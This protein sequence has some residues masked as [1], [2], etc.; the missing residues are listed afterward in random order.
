MKK[1]LAVTSFLLISAMSLAACSKHDADANNAAVNYELLNDE[2][3]ADT[4]SV[5]DGILNSDGVPLDNA[6]VD[7]VATAPSNAL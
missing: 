5:G 2:G 7:N 6:S 4:N 1:L 3:S